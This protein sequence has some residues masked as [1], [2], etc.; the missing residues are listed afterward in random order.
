MALYVVVLALLVVSVFSFTVHRLTVEAV[1]RTRLLADSQDAALLARS[2]M[3]CL[4]GRLNDA[5]LEPTSAVRQT[6]FAENL[7]TGTLLPLG[8]ED[9][10]PAREIAMRLREGRIEATVKVVGVEPLDP[11]RL[12]LGGAGHDPAERR[13]FLRLEA[14]AHVG[15]V[16]NRRV[17]L[18]EYR[19]VH[20][21]PGVIGKYSLY[22]KDPESPDLFNRFANDE[23]GEKDPNVTDNILPIILANGDELDEG[24]PSEAAAPESYRKRGY[25]Y[26]GGSGLTLNLTAGIHEQYGEAFH[27]FLAYQDVTIPGY[28]DPSPSSYYCRPPD[29]TAPRQDLDPTLNPTLPGDKDIGYAVKNVVYGYYTIDPQ[30]RDMN[31]GLNLFKCT[32]PDPVAPGDRRMRS[33]SLHLFGTRSNPSPTLVLGEVRR[34]YSIRSAILAEVDN[35]STRDA[36][37][38]YIPEG[39]ERS[40][41]PPFPPSITVLPGGTLPA[42]TQVHFAPDQLSWDCFVEDEAAYQ[43]RMSRI[44]DEPYLVSHDFL[45]FK[46]PGDHFPSQSL[47]GGGSAET[48]SSFSLNFHES[49][50]RGRLFFSGNPDDLDGRILAGKA[51][52]RVPDANAFVERFI[53]PATGFLDMDCP[54][55]ITSGPG[56]TTVLPD[57]V[58]GKGGLILVE[59]GHLKLGEIK[60]LATTDPDQALTIVVENG[61]IELTREDIEARLIALEGKVLNLGNR[62]RP[63]NLKGTLAAGQF[64]PEEFPAGGKIVWTS[65]ADPSNL[66]WSLHYR[67][68]VSDIPLVGNVE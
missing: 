50:Q 63:L 17:E 57:L 42:G 40:Q 62:Q 1:R 10:A 22:L 12:S 11:Q 18:R 53:D 21:M 28:W 5:L 46:P 31:Y 34:R 13:C 41:L 67:G 16:E 9:L 23:T 33:S 2:A 26:A 38:S 54:V 61:N 8:T 59:E 36:I 39:R 48:V 49:V 3:A 58:L 68:F 24:S 15:S 47:F 35:D 4:M 6:L 25:I 56:S 19:V 20:L 30:G 66:A 27:F 65:L 55:V 44:V 7:A 29:F 60:S 64:S 32:F 52:Y 45:H 43:A 14:L 51:A 37:L